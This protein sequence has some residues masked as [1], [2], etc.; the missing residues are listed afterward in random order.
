ME[1]IIYG[2]V[3]FIIN[4]SMDFLSLYITSKLIHREPSVFALVFGASIGALYGV[5][6]VFQRGN[7]VISF[8]INVSVAMLMCYIIFGFSSIM[9]LIRNTVVFYAVGLLLG[10]SM[11]A[12]Y[13]LINNGLSGRGIVIDG[14]SAVLFTDI[15]IWSF[16]LLAILSVILS[17][18]FSFVLK[19]KGEQKTAKLT[20]TYKNKTVELS[21]LCDSGNLLCEPAGG[22]AVAICSYDK[23][24]PI[25][26]I[27]VRP[28]F[29]ESKVGLLEYCDTEFAK[30]VRMIP[31][32]H[33]GGKGMLVGIIPD[34]AEVNGEEKRLCIACT[35]STESFCGTD[36]IIPMSVL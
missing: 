24:E 2:D 29:Y 33:V 31:A 15:P 32:S 18:V 16:A 13:T 5:I 35:K 3:L 27:G 12:L 14:Q 9:A 21:G 36:C 7:I 10:G 22:A 17:Y 4:F 23:L 1:Q 26:P 8:F 28:L 19:K 25:L 30:R 6:S 20:V 11:T 34:K